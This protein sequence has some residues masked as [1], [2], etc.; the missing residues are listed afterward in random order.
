MK[1]RWVRIAVAALLGCVASGP[2]L[3]DVG[4]RGWG[5][6]V[7]ISDNPDQV[8]VGAHWDLGEF[9]PRVRWQPSVDFGFG[10]N[11]FAF[12]GNLMV[13][14]YFPVKASVTPYAGGQLTAAYFKFHNHNGR[15][16]SDTA[17]G[18]AGVGGIETRLKSG[19]R[20]LAEIQIRLAGDIP[21]AKLLVGWTFK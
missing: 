7:G 17:I 3:S 9:A 5:P 14:Y 16:D 19:I 20:F 2:A 8:V 6:R 1:K 11:T 21:D 18:P 4:Y 13:A 12:T 10:D 15:D